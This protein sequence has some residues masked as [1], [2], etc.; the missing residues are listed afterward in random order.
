MRKGERKKEKS[1]KALVLVEHIIEQF[2]GCLNDNVAHQAEEY[3]TSRIY[4][5]DE[6]Q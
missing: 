2:D 5:S 3:Q 4:D 6:E 1:P